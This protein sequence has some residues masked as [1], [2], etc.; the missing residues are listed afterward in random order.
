MQNNKSTNAV[1]DG[2]INR[3]DLRVER[4]FASDRQSRDMLRSLI[5][6][7]VVSD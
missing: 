1:L 6:A 4:K 5:R 7:H 3:K 2:L